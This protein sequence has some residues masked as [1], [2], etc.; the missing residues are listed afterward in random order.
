MIE[1]IIKILTLLIPVLSKT[2]DK[3]TQVQ[4]I[5]DMKSALDAHTQEFSRED[6][7]ALHDYFNSDS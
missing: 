6:V 5:D 7:D 2:A 1:L 4:D 3:A